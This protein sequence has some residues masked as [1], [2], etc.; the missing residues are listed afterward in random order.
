M[1]RHC[2]RLFLLLCFVASPAASHDTWLVPSQFVV[3]AGGSVRIALN[4]SEAFPTSVAATKPDRIF[5]FALL[6]TT[7][8]KPLA[9]YRVEGDSLVA[10]VG[11]LEPGAYVVVAVTNTRVLVLPAEQFNQY[12]TEEGLQKTIDA[13]AARDQTTKPGRERYAKYAK[14]ILCAAR[15][16]SAEVVTRPVGIRADIV[17][18]RGACQ[19]TRGEAFEVKILFDGKPL[20]GVQVAAGYAGA[21]G[22]HYP[23]I[24]TSDK[25]GR[26]RFTLDRTGAWFV[27][28]LHMIPKSSDAEA[29]WESFFSTLTFQVVE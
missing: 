2:L 20:A 8:E 10:D 21:P 3:A 17:P 23:Q 14:V 15:P 22:H 19:Y 13:R 11:P 24:T 29:D 16:S 28:V 1:T 7:G 9:G 27:R 18:M 25:N 5:R 4:T 12:I 6:G 26:A